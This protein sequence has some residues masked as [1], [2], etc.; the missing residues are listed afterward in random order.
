MKN[1]IISFLPVA[2]VSILFFA[3]KTDVSK[4]TIVTIVGEDMNNMIAAFSSHASWGY[5]D[6]RREGEG[7]ED[8][9]Q[10]VPVAWSISSD[11]KKIFF[12][13]LKE[14]TGK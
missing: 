11:R 5:F 6:F 14:I 2:L 12:N 1:H 9:Y 13:T 4:T 7:F 8:G 10:S 3:C